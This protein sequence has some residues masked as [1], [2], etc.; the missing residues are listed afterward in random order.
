MSASR[1]I[2]LHESWGTDDIRNRAVGAVTRMDGS[3]EV[4]EV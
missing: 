2:L 1:R 4:S 3:D